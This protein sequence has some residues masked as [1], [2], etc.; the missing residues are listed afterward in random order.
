MTVGSR[1]ASVNTVPISD[2]VV[3]LPC[4]PA[5]ATPYFRRISSPSISA[6][7]TTVTLRSRAARTSG[8]FSAMAEEITNRSIPS[9]C[10]GA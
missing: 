2:V 10:S 8:L 5:T 1:P 6:R 3:V 7:L 4:V 9:R